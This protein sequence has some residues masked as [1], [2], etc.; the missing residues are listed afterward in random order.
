[1]TDDEEYKYECYIHLNA[2]RKSIQAEEGHR[3][4]GALSYGY[5]FNVHGFMVHLRQR[6]AHQGWQPAIGS[7]S[8]IPL[9]KSGMNYSTILR[10]VCNPKLLFE[11]FD[12]LFDRSIV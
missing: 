12:Q 5:D 1:M 6:Q 3:C 2:T 8:G 10:T 11:L 4:K 9:S 7:G